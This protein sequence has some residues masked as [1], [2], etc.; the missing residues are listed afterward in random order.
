M[1]MHACAC[2]RKYMYEC[3]CVCLSVFERVLSRTGVGHFILRLFLEENKVHDKRVQST[4][5]ENNTSSRCIINLFIIILIFT[6][7]FSNYIM[8]KIQK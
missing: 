8:I 2:A 1:H 7:K 3:I 5:C 4:H 6:N